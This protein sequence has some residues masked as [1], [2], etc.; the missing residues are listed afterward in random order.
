[1]KYKFNKGDIIKSIHFH[2]HYMISSVTQEGYYLI[3]L[4]NYDGKTSLEMGKRYIDDNFEL[5]A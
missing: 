3:R 1:M 2:I 5:A 4:D